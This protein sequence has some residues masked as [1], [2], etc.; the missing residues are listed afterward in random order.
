MGFGRNRRCTY[1]KWTTCESHGAMIRLINMYEVHGQSECQTLEYLTI[2]NSYDFK[3]SH[4]ILCIGPSSM[5]LL[6]KAY[7]AVLP[8]P[9]PALFLQSA[10][11][12]PK[13]R[14]GN[15][16]L[17]KCEMR[18]DPSLL[19]QTARASCIFYA[20][21]SEEDPE[22]AELQPPNSDSQSRFLPPS[23]TL[24]STLVEKRRGTTDR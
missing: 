22:A 2:M 1:Y 19:M 6:N 23:S 16:A 10:Q 5:P 7:R 14:I 17:P 15:I 4:A 13:R 11:Y 3:K 9:T 24:L 8:S 20:S 21:F 18:N 12:P